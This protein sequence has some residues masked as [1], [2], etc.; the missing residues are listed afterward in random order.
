MPIIRGIR[1]LNR[2]SRNFVSFKCIRIFN[3]KVRVIFF[4]I[5]EDGY[6]FEKTALRGMFN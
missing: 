6:A 4:N 1:T 3:V 2:K 5:P